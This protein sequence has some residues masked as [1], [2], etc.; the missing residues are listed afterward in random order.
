[1]LAKANAMINVFSGILKRIKLLRHFAPLGYDGAPCGGE[2][3]DPS[4][5]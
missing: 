3:P 5:P 4:A 1:M 2:T